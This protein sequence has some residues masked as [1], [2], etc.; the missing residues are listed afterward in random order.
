MIRIEAILLALE[1]LVG[2]EQG[3]L[4][5]EQINDSLTETES[6]LY[7]QAAHPMLTLKNLLSVIPEMGPQNYPSWNKYKFY[8]KGDIVEHNGMLFK[9]RFNNIAQE[10]R[11]AD[12]N[13][14]FNNDY[15]HS[16]GSPVGSAGY[17]EQYDVLSD[18]LRR[19]QRQA[20]TSMVQRFLVEKSLLKESKQILERRTFFDGAGRLANTVQNGQRLVGFEI[21]PAYSMGV[22]AKIERIGLQMTG[23]TGKVRV[24]LFHSS[25]VEP[26]EIRDLE[27][28]KTNGGFQWFDMK[29][30]FLPYISEAN[31]SGGAWYLC[32]DQAALPE[33]MEAVNVAK[34]WSREPCGTCNVG[35]IEAW[36]QLTKFMMISP[37]KVRSSETFEEYPELWDIADNVY[38]NTQ[39]Y[40]LNVE[41]SVYCD[42]TDFIIRERQIFASV[43]QKEMA[44]R[45]LRML[46]FNPSVRVNRN[47]SNASQFDLLYEV[48]GNPQGRE[49]GLGKELKDAYAALDMDTRGIDRLCLTCRPVGVRYG[50][51]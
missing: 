34:D 23:A 41:V 32:Y 10:P 25:Q 14:D 28:T 8:H 29:D 6:G 50:H 45:V 17:W 43:L 1:H 30:M 13:D 49:N 44:A 7:Y 20:I 47:Q 37:F 22:T 27:F 16:N 3:I 19:L 33:G 15:S 48:D 51:V 38:T 4:P 24:Y 12:F 2:W 18:W 9:A 35:S 21:T 40:G 46:A 39:N 31:D 42:L 5:E 36:R 11:T 26:V